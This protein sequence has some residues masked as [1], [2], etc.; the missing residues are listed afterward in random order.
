MIHHDTK[1]S[2]L[3]R[4]CLHALRVETWV[5]VYCEDVVTLVR[6][7]DPPNP[8]GALT[9]PCWG[10][11]ALNPLRTC[12]MTNDYVVSTPM[13]LGLS[14]GTIPKLCL[15]ALIHYTQNW[16]YIIA[17]G[18]WIHLLCIHCQGEIGKSPPSSY[19]HYLESSGV[20]D[21]SCMNFT[22]VLDL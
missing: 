5:T 6:G 2:S 13:E 15:H 1:F 9:Y 17:I 12:G 18:L 4:L 22:I 10:F 3:P 14:S 8:H 19:L 20:E 21:T 11:E 7:Q 16:S